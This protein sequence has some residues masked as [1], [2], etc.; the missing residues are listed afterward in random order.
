MKKFLLVPFLLLVLDCSPTLPPKQC[1]E[2]G[3]SHFVN[4]PEVERAAE[5]CALAYESD[6]EIK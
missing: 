2:G 3:Y 5:M 6:E 4:F 1:G